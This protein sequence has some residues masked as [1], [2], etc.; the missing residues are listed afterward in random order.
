[1]YP[2]EGTT[3][4]STTKGLRAYAVYAKGTT[5]KVGHLRAKDRK[6][7]RSQAAAQWGGSPDDYFAASAR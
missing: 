5:T 1:M 7:A 3:P 6:A 2:T 4:M